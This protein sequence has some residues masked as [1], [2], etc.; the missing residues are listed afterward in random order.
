MVYLLQWKTFGLLLSEFSYIGCISDGSWCLNCC[1]NTGRIV[2]SF[3]WKIS[4][5]N[6]I[7]DSLSTFTQC[8]VRRLSSVLQI[9]SWLIMPGTASVI[10]CTNNSTNK[11]PKR[12]DFEHR[13]APY[14][15][16][17][18]SELSQRIDSNFKTSMNPYVASRDADFTAVF[19]AAEAQKE[20]CSARL[21]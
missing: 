5:D 18:S 11:P 6:R 16:T 21:R 1:V 7:T 4:L 20:L 13:I 17:L 15:E 10:A 3:C 2:T 12:L 8:L 9:L 19:T 14:L